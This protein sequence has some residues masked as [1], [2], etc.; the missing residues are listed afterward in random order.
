MELTMKRI[1]ILLM[2]A[3][4]ASSA[5]SEQTKSVGQP[6]SQ[7][8]GQ[9][10]AR[11]NN[12]G[13]TSC[14][15]VLDGNAFHSRTDNRACGAPNQCWNFLQRGGF[16]SG[17]YVYTQ[18]IQP[19]GFGW[20]LGTDNACPNSARGLWNGTCLTL[21]SRDDLTTINTTNGEA[22]F[23]PGGPC[24]EFDPGII[25]EFEGNACLTG[26]HGGFTDNARNWFFTGIPNAMFSGL[27]FFGH[28]LWLSYAPEQ[29]G[30]NCSGSPAAWQSASPIN[31]IGGVEQ[32]T[33][34][35]QLLTFR[36]TTGFAIGNARC[37]SYA[38]NSTWLAPDANGNL[39]WSGTLHDFIWITDQAS[40][41]IPTVSFLYDLETGL[42]VQNSNI[43]GPPHEA[44][45]SY[46]DNSF[47]VAQI[48]A[49]Q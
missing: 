14:M 11:D 17:A 43:F 4:C 6:L 25:D 29:T 9:I 32:P 31:V 36:T 41:G 45:C 7:S 15:T 37:G 39:M 38:G 8:C 28:T 22:T 18:A 40:A 48:L 19:P 26:Q 47:R 20:C 12:T 27:Q 49:G 42:C 10:S 30:G 46:G 44:T 16:P 35:N 13:A 2:A 23:P 3:G 24:L 5:P 33:T 21:C 1:V 34:N